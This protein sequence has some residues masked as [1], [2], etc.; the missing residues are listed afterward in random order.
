MFHIL[1][2]HGEVVDDCTVDVDALAPKELCQRMIKTMVVQNSIDHVLLG[3]QR[4]GRISF[5][6]TGF[7]EEASVTASAAALKDDDYLFLQYREAAA[8][9]YRGYGIDE[10][11]AQCMGN[12]EDPAKGR[13]MPVH[14]GSVKLHAQTVSSPLGT[15]LPHAAGAGYAYR[16]ENN[17]RVVVCYFGEGAA[18]EGDF[19]AGFNF[20]ATRNSATLFYC[21][22]NGYAISTPAHDQYRGDGILLRGVAYG[23]PSFRVD[24]HDALAVL[25]TTKK[26]RELV[27]SENGTPAFIEAMGYRSGH[28][29]TS[30]DSTS[31]RS[32]EEIAKMHELFDPI[33]RFQKFL[34]RKSWWS[35]KET[36]E[37]A[38]ETKETVLKE[39]N[40]QE[41]LK[42]WPVAE[43]FTDTTAEPTPR[44]KAQQKQTMAHC[45]R[46]KEEYGHL[47][48]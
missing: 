30:D 43:L 8:L 6:M 47:V 39:L 40:R 15:K 44:L 38:A 16:L 22:N 35:Q 2:E 26:A 29:S 20:A 28:H 36:D 27:L 37:L 4:Q 7:Q 45:E 14:Y 3:S 25:H 10:R 13:Q 48:D 23:I 41:H 31:Y 11:I 34:E 5:Y 12:C 21:R 17:G 18:S 42:F 1:N 46:Y 19:H 33:L 32:K 24:G 9:T